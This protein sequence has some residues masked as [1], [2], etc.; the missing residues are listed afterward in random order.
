MPIQW[1]LLLAQV[2]AFEPGAQGELTHFGNKWGWSGTD[3]AFVPQLVMYATPPNFVGDPGK[4]DRDI[5]LFLNDYGFNGFHVFMACRWFDIGEPD[6]R[7]AAGVDPELDP[8]TFEALEMLIRKTHAAGGMVHLWMW[9]DEERGQTPSARDDW[10]GLSG[11]VARKVETAIAERL[12]PLPGWSLGYGF[13]LDEWVEMSEIHAWRDRMTALS[14]T[15]HFWGGRPQGP[16][17]G[18]RHQRYARWNR[19]LDYASYEHHKPSYAVYVEAIEATPD[20]PVMS[21]DRFRVLQSSDQKHYS[22]EEVRRG[23]WHSTLAGG[24]AN[25][26]GFLKDGG[27]HE[28]GSA[29]FPNRAQIRTYFEFVRGRF[30]KTMTRCSPTKAK[31]TRQSLCLDSPAGHH[32]FYRE[33]ARK[34]ELDLRSV[35]D[36]LPVVAVDTLKSYEEIRLGAYRPGLHQWSA[37]YRSDWAI[38]VGSFDR[39]P[40][41]GFEPKVPPFDLSVRTTDSGAVMLEWSSVDSGGAD[42]IV[43]RASADGTTPGSFEPIAMLSDGRTSFLDESPRPDGSHWYRVRAGNRFTVSRHLFSGTQG[44]SVGELRPSHYRFAAARTGLRYYSDRD[45]SLASFPSFLDR[46]RLL[47]AHNDDKAETD[48]QFVSFNLSRPATLYVGFDHRAKRIPYWL[49]EW[50]PV[51]RRVNV[52]GDGMRYFELYRREVPEGP[53]VLGGN[54]SAG[55]EWPDGA[56]SQYILFLVEHPAP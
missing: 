29:R 52:E 18:R 47:V 9:G 11:P 51:G 6:C 25:I 37:P 36:T 15:P 39:D 31:P 26:W 20:K 44:T 56:K 54:S 1:F 34:V 30:L 21:E 5:A 41:P 24:V 38:A 14:S 40:R 13:D 7:E 12:G 19:G 43:E 17:N 46:A 8:R 49:D 22:P 28:L 27:S 10:G 55:G 3:E 48:E 2:L 23:L 32:I 4:L 16:N 42:Y 33:N 53:V 35:S 45:Y 50:E